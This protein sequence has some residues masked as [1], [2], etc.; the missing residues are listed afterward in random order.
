MERKPNSRKGSATSLSFALWGM[1]FFWKN[2]ISTLR[3]QKKRVMTEPLL[4]LFEWM[5]YI[6][7]YFVRCILYIASSWLRAGR[8]M[9]G[10]AG[11]GFYGKE[12]REGG[13]QGPP[14]FNPM[15]GG[16]DTPYLLL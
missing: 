11:V 5:L 16:R 13:V 6:A 1:L 15:G 10:G 12:G 14:P 3:I 8:K 9:G 2:A 7:Y 4:E